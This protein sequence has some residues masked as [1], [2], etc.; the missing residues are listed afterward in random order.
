MIRLFLVLTFFL[1]SSCITSIY[2]KENFRYKFGVVVNNSNYQL[3]R[4]RGLGKRGL[5]Y[6]FKI[7]KKKGLRLP[8]TII[9]MNNGGYR[10]R[11][12]FA[13]EEYR[14]QEELGYRFY[15]A[16][17]YNYRTYLEGLNPLYPSKDIDKKRYIGRDAREI[18]GLREDDQIDGGIGAFKRIMSIVLSPENQPVLFHCN[19]GRHRTGMIAMSIRY[20]QGG[21]WVRPLKNNFIIKLTNKAQVEYFAYNKALPRKGNVEFVEEVSRHKFFQEY[22]ELYREL[23]N[24]EE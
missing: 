7:I 9:H 23:L 15:H 22:V 24:S 21:D 10:S 4:S 12:S 17:D 14:L 8:R 1:M 3:Y 2:K 20:I 19:G 16:Y 11:G 6:V 18:F 5:K 13:M